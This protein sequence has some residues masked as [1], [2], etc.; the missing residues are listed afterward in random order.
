MVDDVYHA[1]IGLLGKQSAYSMYSRWV[2]N[3]WWTNL[4]SAIVRGDNVKACSKSWPGSLPAHWI[5]MWEPQCNLC[6]RS[7]Q[8]LKRL[9]QSIQS[10][11]HFQIIISPLIFP[12]RS[13]LESSDHRTTNHIQVVNQHNNSPA[14]T[15]SCNMYCVIFFFPVSIKL[16]M[17]IKQIVSPEP[18]Y[19]LFANY[20]LIY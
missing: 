7:S 17:Q 10:Y 9:H 4:S 14:Y 12:P 2:C 20:G 13:F 5:G 3:V 8:T 18:N 6:T 16:T 15:I 1:H 11:H 19:R